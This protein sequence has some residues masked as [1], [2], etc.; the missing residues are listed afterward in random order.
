[1]AASN[2]LSRMHR[3]TFPLRRIV[4]LLPWLPLAN[5]LL[6]I[7]FLVN[8]QTKVKVPFAVW[9]I[10]KHIKKKWRS[11]RLSICD[12][13]FKKFWIF[14]LFFFLSVC[15]LICLSARP[16]VCLSTCLL[17]AYLS[18]WLSTYLVSACLPV[19]LPVVRLSV[20]TPICLS[21]YLSVYLPACLLSVYLPVC[22]RKCCKKSDI[23]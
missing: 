3:W 19:R 18:V 20:C 17:F 9:T 11:C 8:N 6:P 14:C 13:I 23:Y 22:L 16:S 1:M 7:F 21:A 4:P 10:R 5:G 12:W 2:L 15:P